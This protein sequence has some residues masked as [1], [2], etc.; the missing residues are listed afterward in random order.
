MIN[1]KSNPM[2]TYHYRMHQEDLAHQ[3]ARWYRISHE[4]KKTVCLLGMRADESLQRYSGFLNK[5]YGYKE[6]AGSQNSLK[7]SGVL[8]HL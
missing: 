5:Q 2:T 1:L 8:P 4:N 3:F 6:N 7:T